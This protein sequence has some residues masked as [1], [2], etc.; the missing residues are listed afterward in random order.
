MVVYFGDGDG[1]RDEP[2]SLQG[3]GPMRAD[4]PQSGR[5]GGLTIGT[6]ACLRPN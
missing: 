4:E 1:S 2:S 5:N 3:E 6:V